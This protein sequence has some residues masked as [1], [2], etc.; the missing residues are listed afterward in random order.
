MLIQLFF[1]VHLGTLKLNCV[2]SL[3]YFLLNNFVFRLHSVQRVP[4][5]VALW[6]QGKERGYT[7]S[8][9]SVNDD[10]RDE[11]LF[12]SSVYVC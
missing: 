12:I 11:C 1:A 3:T 8:L 4:E 10:R 5:A 2:T 9:T 6:S 7:H